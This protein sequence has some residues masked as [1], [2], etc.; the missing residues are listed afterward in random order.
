VSI[1]PNIV[2]LQVPYGNPG[3]VGEPLGLWTGKATVVGDAS[4]GFVAIAFVPQNP[5]DTP[6][7]D[8]QRRQFVWFIDGAG[9]TADVQPGNLSSLM[10]AHWD[11]SNAALTPPFSQ[12]VTGDSLDD[13]LGFQASIPL[14]PIEWTRVP[15]FWAPAELGSTARNLIVLRAQTN[16]LNTNYTFT[17]YGRYYDKSILSNRAFG[18]LVSP[19]A[20]SQFEG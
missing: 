9:V 8:D 12:G 14:V 10:E 7:L 18:R 2:V 13:G 5:A 16:T 17:A 1:N 20:M 11:R 6:T 15:I 4:G 3:S 19:V